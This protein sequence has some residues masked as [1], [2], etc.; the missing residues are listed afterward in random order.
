[1]SPQPR[2]TGLPENDPLADLVG[3]SPPIVA[4][5]ARVRRLLQVQT[6]SGRLPA[7]LI[8]GETGTGKGLLAR[9]LH[10]AG[11]RAGGPFQAI[12]CAALPDHLVESELFGFE[13]GAFTDARQAKPGLFQ[14][15]SGGTLFLDE[16]GLLPEAVQAKILTAIE[17]RV[18]RRLGGTRAEPVDVRLIAATNVDLAQAVGEGRFREDLYHRL[19]VVTLVLPPLRERGE[20]IMLLAEQFLERACRDYGVSAK[21]ILPEARERLLASPWRGNVRELGNVMERVALLAEGAAVTAAMLGLDT[22]PAPP[23]AAPPVSLD[24]AVR[25]RL[26]DALEATGW[27][28]SEVARQL[29][30]T[31]NTVRARIE[32]HGLRP[33]AA[34]PRRREPAPAPAPAVSRPPARVA[35]S[36]GP[37][38]WVTRRVTFLHAV[39]AGQGGGEVYDASD[40]IETLVEKVETFGGQVDG[41]SPS[42]VTATFGVEA[43]EDAAGRAGH[44]A[45]AIAKAAERSR[46]EDADAPRVRLAIHLAQLQVLQ[47]PDGSAIDADARRRALPVLEALVAATAG[48]EIVV[49][50]AAAAFLARRFD[51]ARRSSEGPDGRPVYALMG[52]ERDLGA[53]GRTTAFVGRQEEMDLLHSRLQRATEGRGQVVGIVGEAGLGKT[54][55]LDEWR[56]ALPDSN[57]RFLEGQC[58]AHGANL[59]FLPVLEIIRRAFRIAEADT[60]GQTAEKVRIALAGLDL[61]ATEMAPYLLH[62]LGVAGSSAPLAAQS[63]EAMHARTLEI[64][65]AVSLKGSVARPIVM[66]IED[67]HWMDHASAAY[68]GSLVERLA[69]AKIMLVVTYREEYRP[70]WLQRSY[71]TQV[72]LQPLAPEDSRRAL[73]SVLAGAPVTPAVEELILGRAEGNPFF[74]EELARTLVVPQGAA[75][76]AVPGTVQEVLLARLERLTEEDRELLQ[77]AS[78]L[79]RDFSPALLQAVT[80]GGDLRQ[81]LA[82]LMDA[83]F[84]YEAATGGDALC[85]FRHALTQDVAYESLAPERRR[86]LHAAAGRALEASHAG[87]VDDV[88]DQLAFHYGA[89]DARDKA[90]HYLGRSAERSAARYANV[91]AATLLSQA[92]AH[93]ERLTPGPDTDRT[94]LALTFRQA[95]SL[96]L[97]GQFQKILERLAAEAPRASRLG[98]AALSAELHF[99]LGRTFSI[100]GQRARATESGQRA[101]AEAQRS[102]DETLIGKAH[103]VLGYE[104]YWSGPLE[105]GVRHARLAVEHLERG[106]DHYWLAMAYWVLA[107]NHGPMGDWSAALEALARLE[108]IANATSDPKLQSAAAW[109]TGSVRALRGDWDL[110]VIAGRRGLELSPNPLNTALAMGFLGAIYFEKSDLR[111]AIPLLEKAIEQISAFK[112]WDMQ[113]W[114]TAILGEAHF[115]GGD[116]ARARALL[117]EAL[118]M[119]QKAG[120]WWG[121][122]W[123]QR[124]LGRMALAARAFD[125]ARDRL[126]GALGAMRGVGARFEAARTGLTLAR[127]EHALGNR[128]AAA[129]VL[130]EAYRIIAASDAPVYVALAQATARD[131]NLPLS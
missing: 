99:W 89:S 91:E 93:A 48:E 80:G 115:A 121:I 47:G 105:E 55:L 95:H 35:P 97:L 82:A 57:I 54:R 45:L 129:E 51:L 37:R 8:Q 2:A 98:D 23:A 119:S 122:G 76:A 84:L 74:L 126:R 24:A 46:R 75:P 18:V 16:I 101:L 112:T 96:G 39:V 103:Y 20:D 68:V 86:A 22:A 44:A 113:G 116:P 15:A 73:R 31:R 12:N 120:Y 63:P 77:A 114:L 66:I 78:V 107:L 109:T 52:R 69:G 36:A 14:T 125:E 5:R 83:E 9:T 111:E 34:P 61:P 71:V 27:N 67:L 7:L 81:R 87:R 64:L 40:L 53:P 43:T 25:T 90:I 106:S 104:C 59:P 118:A 79:G 56:R 110:G 92:L 29:G 28:I 11:P 19:A 50:D 88:L 3:E 100:V 108:E 38:R 33:G 102:G 42:G 127:A 17:D 85:V 41:V 131:L 123:A 128:D 60:P 26:F 70:A 124:A 13:R 32:K 62:F 30:I 10:R 49:S 72:A 1:M 21:R 65:L 6:D 130:T 94:V 58:Q 117:E 4:L